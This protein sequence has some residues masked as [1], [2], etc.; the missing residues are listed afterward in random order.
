[1]KPVEML[2]QLIEDGSPSGAVVYEPFCGSGSTIIA[3]EMLDRR[4]VAIELDPL[5]VDVT[6]QRW[7]A[8]TGRKAERTHAT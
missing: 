7:E 1:M 3:A 4:C 6:V 2:K 8:F 5:Y